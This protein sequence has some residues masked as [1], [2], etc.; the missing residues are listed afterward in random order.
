MIPTGARLGRYE[1]LSRIGAGGMGEVY[2][3]RDPGL[4]R[5][6]AIKVLPGDFASD[7]DRLRRFEQEARAAGALNHPNV[8][9]VHDVGTSEGR[10]FMVAELL[11]GQD[12]RG[13]IPGAGFAPRRAAE[14]A[15]QIAHGLA[16]AHDKGIVHRDLKP[17]NV[18][19]TADQRVKILD[20]GL[21]KLAPPRSP[22]GSID[23]TATRPGTVL[24]TVGYMAPEQVRG[25]AADRGSDVFAF[26]AILYE[27][28]SGR[29]A[30]ARPSGAETLAAILKEDV[31]PLA[32]PHETAALERIARRCLEKDP[33]ERFQSARDVAFALEAVVASWDRATGPR[34]RPEQPSVAVLPFKDLAGTGENA[35]LGLGLADA[36]ITELAGVRSLLVR[37]TAAIL[38]YQ[39]RAWDPEQAGRE[40]EVDAVVDGSFQRSGSRL[41]VTVQLID[42]AG[43]RPLWAT[44][45]DG[46]LDDVFRT[47]DEVSRRIAQALEVE[48]TPE[49]ERRLGRGGGGST[50]ARESYLKGRLLLLRETLEDYRSAVDHLDRARRLD[51]SFALAWAALAD[52][53][54]RIAYEFEPGG[55]WVARAQEACAKAMALEPS[56]PEVRYV[57][58]RLL[59]T[60]PAGF[61]HA[62]ALREIM[63]AIALRP[64]LDEAHSRVAVIL[65][66][67]GLNEECGRHLDQA[68]AISPANELTHGHRAGWRYHQGRFEEAL[69]IARAVQARAPH[70]WVEYVSAHALLRLGRSDEVGRSIPDHREDLQSVLGLLAALRGDAGEAQR[71]VDLTVEHRSA[72]GHYHHAQ[73]DI[74]LIHALLGRPDQAVEWLRRAARNGYPCESFFRQDPFLASLRG[75]ERF[76]SLMEELSRRVRRL[77]AGL[78]RGTDLERRR[79]MTLA[80]GDRLG[81]YEILT[82]LGAGGM[83]EVYRAHDGRLGREVAVKVLPDAFASD[84]DRA[85]RFDREARALATLNHPGIATI[86]GV[87]E[88]SGLKFLVLE[89]VPGETLEERLRQGPLPVDEALPIAASIA[90]ALEAA[91]DKGIVHRDLKP[92]NVKVT[93]EGGV[94]VLDFGLAKAAPD[95]AREVSASPT[96]TA[97][98]TRAGA[99]LGTPVYMSPEQSRG[100]PVDKRTD[101][102]SFGCLL[103][104]MLTGARTF[105]GE[106][107]SDVLAAIL[108][109]EPDW[110]ALPV[111]TPDNVRRLLRHCLEKDPTRRLRDAGDARLELVAGWRHGPVRPVAPAGQAAG[112][113]RR[114]RRLRERRRV[115]GRR[116]LGA[117]VEARRRRLQP[118]LLARRR[119]GRGRRLLGRPAPPLGARRAGPQSAAGHDRRVRGDLARAAPLVARRLEAG[120]PEHRAHQVRRPGGGPRDEDDD[121]AHQRPRAGRRSELVTRGTLCLL[122]LG[123]RRRDQHLAGASVG[124]GRAG[125]RLRAAHHW[126]G[127]GRGAGPL[128][129]RAAGLHDPE[130]ERRPLEAARVAPGRPAG[131]RAAA[132][133]V[134]Y[135]R[136]QPRGLVAGRARDRLQLR[137]ERRDEH[138]GGERRDAGRAPLTRGPGGDFQPNWS[139]DGRR[140]AF[141]SSRSGNADVWTVEVDSGRVAQLTRASALDINPF[142]SPDGTHIAYQSDQGGRLE[143]WVMNANGSD[144]RPLTQVGVTGHFLRWSADGQAVVFRCPC[145]GKP[146]VMQVPL[147]GGEPQAL[148]EVAGGSHLSFSPDHSAIVDV[149]GHK[150]LWVSPLEGGQPYK[151]FE[152]DDPDAR[153]DYPVWSPEGRFVLMDRFRP[154]G[155]DV[156]L[157]EHV[158]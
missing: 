103:Y 157:M 156:W 14:L 31:P 88:Q 111:S 23:E 67:V 137:P 46:T 80:A 150:T 138:L 77:P 61:D 15:I 12:L 96:L 117:R 41:R 114:V 89:L 155:G 120:L 8:L 141:F 87:E 40:L 20:F 60:P 48:L 139:P 51:P 128:A 90:A 72:Y 147:A 93:P 113:G 6:V 92:A 55:D 19:V 25:E 98:G 116:R 76:E 42:V 94:K 30:F 132:R 18:F 82:S 1:V 115:G 39:D 32:G 158:E 122:L 66:H 68:M 24:G 13:L 64:N 84:P 100:K 27:M 57:R 7:P 54:S 143:V 86:Y 2:R 135:P 59:W 104:E 81:T 151:I 146:Q 112:A 63:A 145:G 127:P 126:R 58:G 26:G 33:S 85:A 53:Y 78:R 69:E 97:A 34:R 28:L 38:R 149:V 95:A 101:L 75:E 144:A 52:V 79:H 131:R 21:A 17:E 29:R 11:E 133:R 70:W 107:P 91:H 134:H 130:A 121:L 153:I 36:T 123:P 124:A 108:T 37:P 22:E 106:T 56:L 73:Y 136:G 105:D 110:S 65:Y 83:G 129:R 10:P 5:E 3:A 125:R 154:Q 43:G 118:R 62:G 45:I 49:E 47:Q 50:E 142:F 148:P 71:R 109:R 35:H 119:A 140:I 74:A 152:F 4:G 99:V 102:W 9:A 16:A 44:K